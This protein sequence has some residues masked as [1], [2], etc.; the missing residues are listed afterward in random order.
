MAK[1]K[2]KGPDFG[3]MVLLLL[4]VAA[5][6]VVLHPP[7]LERALTVWDELRELVAPTPQPPAPPTSSPS[8]KRGADTASWIPGR[9]DQ[10]S[11]FAGLPASHGYP[12]SITVLT[13][14]AF[15]IGYDEVTHNPA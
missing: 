8:E 3:T 11:T 5:A 2:K 9:Y 12:N 7:A 4:L 1:R 13:T 14:P 6:L 15:V 10:S